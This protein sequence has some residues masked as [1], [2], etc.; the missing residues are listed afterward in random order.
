MKKILCL[1]SAIIAISCSKPIKSEQG[2]IDIVTN[3]Y[4]NVSKGLDDMKSIVLSKI[5]YKNDTIIELVPN[6]EYPEF[7]DRIFL[8]KDTLAFEINEEE[9]AKFQYT[10]LKDK[11]PFSVYKKGDGALFS[12]EKM[13]NFSNRYDI[14]DTLLFGKKY[15]RF[16]INNF[17]DSTYTTFYIHPT[18]T[19]LPY[20]IYPKE[21]KEYNGRIERM[22]FYDIKLDRFISIQLFPRK[23]WDK[24]AKNIFDFNEFIK[25][26]K[27]K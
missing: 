15:K 2:R 25:K 26:R 1:F 18:D 3:I 5:N 4:F 7:I 23:E 9:S 27:N 22:D 19:I 8:I 11:K 13:P 12:E 17:I 6:V 24:E 20:A 21:A 10:F 14:Q 16:F